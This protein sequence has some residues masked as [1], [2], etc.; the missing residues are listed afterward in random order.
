MTFLESV[1]AKARENLRTIV[2][3]E[4]DE[5]RTVQAAAIL[6][7]EGL[8]LPVLIGNPESIR[9]AAE[10]TGADLSGIALTD[11]ETSLKA[12]EYAAALYELRKAKGLTEEQAA[13]LVRDPMYF[14]MMMVK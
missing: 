11:P 6:K 12:P 7:K 14:G 9:K 3:P 5:K 1:K 8:A 4:G 13:A 2:F 10:A